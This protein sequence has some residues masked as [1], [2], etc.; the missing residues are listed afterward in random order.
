MTPIYHNVDTSGNFNKIVG[1][2]SKARF[3]NYAEL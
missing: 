1:D 2:E 3:Y